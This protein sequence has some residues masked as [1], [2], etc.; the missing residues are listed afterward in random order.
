MQYFDE[1]LHTLQEQMADKARLEAKKKVLKTQEA[2]FTTRLKELEQ[3]KW[4]EESDVAKLERRSLA[5]FYYNVV[6]KMDGMLT[7]EREE[8]YAAQVKYDAAAL[9]LAEVKK[10]LDAIGSALLPLRDCERKY[11]ETL[12]AKRDAI[13]ADKNPA[14]E[15]IWKLETL[16]IHL[17][18]QKKEI[19]EAITA[20]ERARSVADQILSSLGSAESWG[21]WD[22]FGG[23]LVADVAKHSHLDDAQSKVHLL[24]DMLRRFKTELADVKI[25]AQMQVQ[26]D[27]F[28]RFADFFFDGLFAD[29]TVLGQIRDSQSQVYSVRKQLDDA[30]K[31]LSVMRDAADREQAAAKAKC[32]ELI[33]TTA[34]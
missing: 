14:A 17:D 26:V 13:I 22:V 20:G 9:S 24:Q 5:N 29:W 3:A 6:G 27:G 10:E 23:G 19:N 21:K 12:A 8:A 7:K 2:M 33:R 15:E 11:T 32:A 4:Q 31:K 34:L 28:L 18:R 25:Q 30:L 1:T 16:H